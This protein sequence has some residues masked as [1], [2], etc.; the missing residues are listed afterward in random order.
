MSNLHFVDE[1]LGVEVLFPFFF[2]FFFSQITA[3][4]N[5]TNPKL[6]GKKK[7]IS[8]SLFSSKAARKNLKVGNLELRLVGPFVSNTG[9]LDGAAEKA[10][11]AVRE[12]NGEVP[13][14]E[15][16]LWKT[17]KNFYLTESTAKIKNRLKTLRGKIV[18]FTFFLAI[19]D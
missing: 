18:S 6:T 15:N 5:Q 16:D 7:W 9:N 12:F 3:K 10:R 19:L 11:K 2:F 8:F 1:S 14:S 13:R 17:I 4:M